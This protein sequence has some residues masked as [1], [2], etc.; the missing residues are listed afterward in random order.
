MQVVMCAGAGQLS[1]Q[2]H[3]IPELSADM[4]RAK[5]AFGG[6]CGSD[7]HYYQHGGFGTVRVK[8]PLALGHEVSGVVDAVGA[9]DANHP[10]AFFIYFH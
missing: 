3:P 2:D 1:V 8:E 10:P 9:V 6:I 5:V 4:I 7:L